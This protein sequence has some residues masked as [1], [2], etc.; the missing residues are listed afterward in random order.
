LAGLYGKKEP[1]IAKA[2]AGKAARLE[3]AAALKADFKRL[4]LDERLSVVF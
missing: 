2:D 1:S 4:N 3:A